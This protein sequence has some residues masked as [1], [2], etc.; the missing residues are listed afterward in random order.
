MGHIGSD[1]NEIILAPEFPQMGAPMPI[2]PLTLP[3]DDIVAH[4]FNTL[5]ST[6]N[7]VVFLVVGQHDIGGV[8]K[9][10][11]DGLKPRVVFGIFIKL[12]KNILRGGEK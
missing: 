6:H 12:R 10:I 7:Q 8:S 4:F 11:C 5:E 9:V 1:Y 3:L 2:G